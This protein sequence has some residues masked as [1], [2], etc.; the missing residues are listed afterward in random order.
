LEEQEHTM[1]G[2]WRLRYYPST[3]LGCE[4]LFNRGV[5]GFGMKFLKVNSRD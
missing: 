1:P 2:C 4:A 5:T 3:I